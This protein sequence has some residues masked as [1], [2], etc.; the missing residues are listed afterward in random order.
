MRPGPASQPG[1]S[2]IAPSIYHDLWE[3]SL[4]ACFLLHCERDNSGQI[5]DFVFDDMNPRGAAALG[6]EKQAAIGKR[7]C[8][9]VPIQRRGGLF[10]RY[11]DVADSRVSLD[12]EYEL[13][14]AEVDARWIRQQVIA[15]HNGIAVIAQNISARK[16]EEFANQ[17]NGVFLQTL[18]DFLPLLISAKSVRPLD[19]GSVVIWNKAAQRI[20]GYSG[21][22][23]VDQAM[24]EAVPPDLDCAVNAIGA[25]VPGELLA[26]ETVIPFVTRDGATRELRTTVVPLLNEYGVPEFVLGIAEDITELTAARTQLE[27]HANHDALTGLPN[28]RLFMDRL[29]HALE[30]CGRS[31]RGVSLLFVD[32]DNFK[33]VNDREGHGIGD[34]LLKEVGERLSHSARSVDTVCRLSGDEFPIVMEDVEEASRGEADIVA[35]RILHAL[36]RPFVLDGQMITVTAS[37][38]ISTCPADGADATALLGRADD[39]LYRAKELGKNRHQHFSPTLDR[40]ADH[41]TVFESERGIAIAQTAPSSPAHEVSS[42]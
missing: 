20:T 12:E 38:G 36:S 8:E 33:T 39:A 42:G 10:N 15:T 7:L 27:R 6:L 3:A 28:R 23:V 25:G 29:T 11:V 26:A 18:V 24:G 41:R 9:V 1:E 14:L 37:I 5:T 16:R 19:Y 34:A 30:R 4:D 21:D 22:D 17:R 40:D 35:K 32:L 13:N 2:V 31:S